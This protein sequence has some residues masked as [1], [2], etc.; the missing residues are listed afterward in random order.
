MKTKPGFLYWLV[1]FGL[2]VGSTVWTKPARAAGEALPA[3]SDQNDPSTQDYLIIFPVLQP[4][5]QQFNERLERPVARDYAHQMIFQQAAPLLA[6]LERLKD[7]GSLSK[8]EIKPELHGIA[9]YGLA[10]G[11]INELNLPG[12]AAVL[13]LGEEPPACAAAAAQALTRQVEGISQTAGLRRSTLA[14]ADTGVQTTNPSIEVYYYE[15][16]WGGVSGQTNGSISVSLRILRGGAVQVTESTTSSNDG[17]YYF[18]PDWMGCPSNTYSWSLRPGDVVEVTAAGKTYR[19]VVA[20]LIA[21]ADPLAN[22]ISGNT[23]PGRTVAITVSQRVANSCQWSDFSLTVS[24][25][26]NG[27]FSANFGSLV[28]FDRSASVMVHSRDANGNSTYRYSDPFALRVDFSRGDV[29]GY[30]KPLTA[31]TLTLLRGGNPI[32]TYNDTTLI[33]GYFYGWFSE[34]LQPGDVVAASGGGVTVQITIAPLSGVSINPALNQVSGTTAPNR[35]MTISLSKA[36]GFYQSLPSSCSYGYACFFQNSGSA[37]SFAITSTG[38]DLI[39]GDFVY[40]DIYDN[41]GNV[42]YHSLRVPLIS[43]NLS[44]QR[45]QGVWQSQPDTYLTITHKDGGG[46]V[47]NVYNDVWVYWYDLTFSVSLVG[48]INPG[49]QFEISDGTLTETM[50]VPAALPTARLNSSTG[51][52]TG[53]APSGS[54]QVL[55]MLWDYR[56]DTD[57][58]ETYCNEANPASPGAFD[59]TFS[60]AQVS[61]GDDSSIYIRGADGHYTSLYRRAFYVYHWLGYQDVNGSTESP[62][63]NVTITLRRGTTVLDS[64]IRS[65]N[66]RGYWYVFLN[67]VP[68][69]GDRI[70]VT[71][72]DGNTVNL[73]LPELTANEDVPANRIYGKSP[74]GRPVLVELRRHTRNGF[75]RLNQVVNADGEGNYTAFFNNLYWSR[76]CSAVSLAHRCAASGL[77][78]YTPAGHGIFLWGEYPP[79][80]PAD[81]FEPDNDMA[82]AVPYSVSQTHTFHSE[83]DED[84]VSFSVPAGDVHTYRYQISTFNTGWEVEPRIDLYRSDGTP[85]AWGY[86]WDGIQWLPDAAGTYYIKITPLDDY[87]AAFCDAYY[88]VLI[89]PVRSEIFLPAI[90]RR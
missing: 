6:E 51:R 3:L 74:A 32:D 76:D 38:F 29:F 9:L 7:E 39:R 46:S 54:S 56:P 15:D 36:I 45:L 5:A 78:Y 64:V 24:P 73:D 80:A 90:T 77:R 8:F 70:E 30:L 37:G 13:P 89:Q 61:G 75:N 14:L 47:Q 57:R 82:S 68:N 83:S 40:L 20:N 52:L 49:D 59:L 86:G 85:I 55:A 11:K 79:P 65:S 22:Q 10:S 16:G 66:S 2:L 84:W 31:Y 62:N 25:N 60:G 53:N 28:D 58:L 71:T 34:Q 41:E 69:P 27:D 88:D 23:D 42:Q 50:V 1:I 87:S 48:S 43:A 44:N 18:Y 4:D 33:N 17:Y 12:I 81:S 19:T 63:V 67:S 26:A 72:A 21:W 35:H